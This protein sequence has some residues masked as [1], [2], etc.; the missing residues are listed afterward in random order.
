MM[1][2]TCKYVCIQTKSSHIIHIL[3]PFLLSNSQPS[4]LHFLPPRPSLRQI[5]QTHAHVVVSGHHARITA[6]LLSLLSLSSPVPFPLHY[7]LSL[8][9]SILFPTVFAFNSLIRCHAKANSSPSLSLSLYSSMRR[10]FLNPSQH[11]FTS[12]VF[13]FTR[14]WLSSVMHATCLFGTL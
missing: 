1:S 10:R 11:T 3:K 2:L 8:F 12:W 6:H 13:T 7:S 5:K 14:T 4:I 9:N